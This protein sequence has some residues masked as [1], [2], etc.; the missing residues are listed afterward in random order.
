MNTKTCAK[1]I[2]NISNCFIERYMLRKHMF[3]SR[4]PF[5]E[6]WTCSVMTIAA[7]GCYKYE[8]ASIEWLCFRTIVR[9]SSHQSIQISAHYFGLNQQSWYPNRSPYWHCWVPQ[10]CWLCRL[11]LRSRWVQRDLHIWPRLRTNKAKLQAS[12][13]LRYPETVLN[14]AAFLI[15]TCWPSIS[16]QVT[17]HHLRML[18]NCW[19]C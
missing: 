9:S 12:G 11:H 19:V 18:S 10:V 15:S 17:D 2:L 4:D 8:R 14:N 6:C 7:V 13:Q 5:Y 1:D 16:T 3:G